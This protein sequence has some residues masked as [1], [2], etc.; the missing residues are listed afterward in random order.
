MPSILIA[1]CT[2]RPPRTIEPAL[3]ALAPQVGADPRS[4]LLVVTSAVEPGERPALEQAV[5]SRGGAVVHER[6]PGL[7]VARNRALAECEEDVIAFLDDDATPRPDWL[8]AL[9]REWSRE[10]AGAP[11]GCVGGPILPLWSQPP[12]EWLS[13]ELWKVLTLLDRGDEPLDLDPAQS[14]V[15]GANISF[16]AAALRAAGGF[17]P[18]LGARPDLPLTG[19][20]DAAQ[21]AL[22]QA[23]YRIHYAPSV[24]VE[25]RIPVARLRR[26]ELVRRRFHYGLALGLRGRRS[27]A[28]AAGRLARSA[29]G[30]LLA[31]L[32]RRDRLAVERAVRAAENAGV[33]ALPLMRRR[34]ASGGSAEAR[35]TDAPDAAIVSLGT[36]AGLRHADATLRELLEQSGLGTE[37]VSV[38]LG[39]PVLRRRWRPLVDLGEALAARRA[40]RRA[41]GDAGEP[42]PALV[43]STSTA[44]LLQPRKL[45]EGGPAAIRFDSPAAL[46]RRGAGGLVQR[47]LE[48]RAFARAT[49]LLPWSEPAAAAARALA[50]ATALVVLPPPVEGAAAEGPRDLPAVAYAANPA[51]RGLDLLCTAWADAG[52]GELRVAGIEPERAAAWLRGRGMA[53]PPGVSFCGLL[54]PEAFRELL[55][56][57]R[58]FVN[59]SRW[60]DFGIA[61]LEALAAGALLVTVPSPG[62]YAALGLARELDPELVATAAEPADLGGA[63]AAGLSRTP[64]QA[65]SYRRRAEPLLAPYRRETVA[66]TVRR[67]VAPALRG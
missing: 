25:H 52:E 9:R 45:W 26:R 61:Q 63:L 48:R 6:K 59:A 41:F 3:E 14:T 21:V 20:E 46:N 36:T 13:P 10:A 12:P 5:G 15:W 35:R 11:L 19:E 23:G 22:A 66:E 49:L 24:V 17:D 56:Q 27:R 58:V 18:G 32:M 65:S 53:P 37:L 2:N 44:A 30:A 31:A 28:R 1:I 43:F 42:R 47:R 57:A 39:R 54:A 16:D 64:E 8:E 55:G 38:E 33:L 67:S 60:E 4:R 40:A 50:G 34:L 51:K 29:L 7:S 62:P